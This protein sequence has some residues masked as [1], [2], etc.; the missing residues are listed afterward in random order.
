LLQHVKIPSEIWR[1]DAAP[2]N[3]CLPDPEANEYGH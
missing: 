2:G 1:H 3:A